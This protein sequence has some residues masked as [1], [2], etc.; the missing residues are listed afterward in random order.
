MYLHSEV[1]EKKLYFAADSDALISKGLAMLLL[2]LYNGMTAE[3]I[4]KNPPTLL[5]EIGL[6]G[7][8]TQGRANGLSG[9]Y[10]KMKQEALKTLLSK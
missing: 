1:R 10:L 3:Y 7:A 8:L 2:T 9:L 5:E 6:I 4:L